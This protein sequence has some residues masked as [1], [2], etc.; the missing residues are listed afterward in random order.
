MYKDKNLSRR[1]GKGIVPKR[2]ILR[3]FF[4]DLLS[5][6]K[7]NK[8]ELQTPNT[9]SKTDNKKKGES[10]YRDKLARKLK[11]QTEVTTPVGRIDILTANEIIEVKSIKQWKAALGQV[12][13][14]GHY[15]PSHRK[16]IHLFGRK[17]DVNSSLIERSCL[18]HGVF[19]SWEDDEV[20]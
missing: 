15:Y 9:K 7:P 8:K 18:D 14:Y 17:L 16:R 4:R 1:V 13:A 12:I 11:G 6:S 10:Y 20:V 5:P 2:E 19:V 3:D